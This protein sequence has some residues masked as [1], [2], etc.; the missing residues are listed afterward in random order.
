MMHAPI[1]N[2]IIFGETGSGK[3]SII[4]L[5]ADKPIAQTASSARGC[6]F[7]S[8]CYPV[9]VFG[10]T[11]NIYDTVGLSEGETGRVPSTDAIVQL[12]SLLQNLD[13]GVNLL[14][15]CM[16]GPRF[17][18]V[19]HDNWRF[20]HNI[21]CQRNVPIVLAITGLENEDVMCDWW[22]ANKGAFQEHRMLPNDVA[23]I[24]ATKGKNNVF[25]AEYE[26]SRVTMHRV[27]RDTALEKP[28]KVQPVEWFHNI[29]VTT[30]KSQWCPWV[31]KCTEMQQ[32]VGPGILA[33][34]D[35][36]GFPMED[37]KRLGDL[38]SKVIPGPPPAYTGP[39]N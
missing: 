9:T 35:L 16:R 21:V 33:M 13:K 38:L 6:T 1:P 22:P 36:C 7:Q 39:E 14:V 15:F 4:N 18:S 30:F 27:L 5:L 34:M 32:V 37:A 8:Q 17:K 12:Y 11:F 25:E 19:A 3:S 26:E 24:T 28:W 23:C 29:T 10:S 2:I 31:S 20:F